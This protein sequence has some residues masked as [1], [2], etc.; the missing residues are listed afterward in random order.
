[1][2]DNSDSLKPELILPTEV[3]SAQTP[4]MV[5]ADGLAS[6]PVSADMLDKAESQLTPEELAMVKEFAQ[7][8]DVTNTAQILQYGAASQQKMSQFSESALENVRT[9]DMDEVGNMIT[10]LVVELKGFSSE[11]ESKGIFGLFKKP[12]K[13]MA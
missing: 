3:I 1:M 8:I 7:K 13:K 10:G 5:P 6:L 9:K 2:T 4:D 12:G 11:E